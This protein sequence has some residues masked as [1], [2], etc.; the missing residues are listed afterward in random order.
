MDQILLI[1]REDGFAVSINGKLLIKSMDAREMLWMS[2][3]CQKV[4]LEMLSKEKREG[5]KIPVVAIDLT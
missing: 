4:G 3:R 1:P 5:V 2:L